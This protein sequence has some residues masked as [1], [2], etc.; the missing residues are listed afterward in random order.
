MLLLTICVPQ[1]LSQA[2]KLGLAALILEEHQGWWAQKEY[3][4]P[5]AKCSVLFLRKLF[6]S[7]AQC[8]GFSAQKGRERA[9]RP[10]PLVALRRGL[11][12]ILR[13]VIV[14]RNQDFVSRLPALLGVPVGRLRLVGVAGPQGQEQEEEAVQFGGAVCVVNRTTEVRRGG[15]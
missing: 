11:K 15:F 6:S 9:L 14:A 13:R 8:A 1:V 12:K 10:G 3:D 7:V 4:L 2:N 5:F